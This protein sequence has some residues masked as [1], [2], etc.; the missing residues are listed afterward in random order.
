MNKGNITP[1]VYIEEKSA[2]PNS[3]IGVP[4]AIPAF[5]GYTEKAANKDK[6]LKN[7]PTRI[8]SLAEFQQY[9]GGAPCPIFEIIRDAQGR[10]ELKNP[11]SYFLLYYSMKFFFAN[12]GSDCYVVSIGDY[13]N[14]VHQADFNGEIPV[15]DANGHATAAI[16]PIGIRCLEQAPEP[17][18]LVIPDAVLLD[19]KDCAEIQKA[20]LAHCSRL[21]N[22]FAILDVP[23]PADQLK[24]PATESLIQDFRKQ[25]GASNLLWGAAYYPYLH[26]SVTDA[27]SISFRNI[28]PEN[29]ELLL[30]LLLEEQRNVKQSPEALQETEN[31]LKSILQKPGEN[32]NSMQNQHQSLL[33]LSPLYKDI[34][35]LL[36]EKINIL[37]PSGAMAGIYTTVDSNVGVFQSPANIS[38]GSALSTVA[39]L[40]NAEQENLNM[41]ID[42]KAVNAIRS[43]PGKGVLVWGARTLDGNSQDWRYINVR[44]TVIFLQQSIKYALLP[45]TF[46]ANNNSTWANV[47]AMITNFLATVW[48]N[49]GL[50]GAEP[51][52]AF[53]V[54]V[55]LGVTMTAVDVQEGLMRVSVKV[56]L[57][58]PA[59]FIVLDFEQNMQEMA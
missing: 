1:G 36:L 45:Y 37:P 56:A 58:R 26:T 35:R 4:T 32:F 47:E 50:A 44:R 14:G 41:P 18:L 24:M 21:G 9:F 31:K 30:N 25:I 12:G 27:N 57:V 39:P 52:D 7:V 48:R 13:A 2:F 28:A 42:G 59:E 22:R 11:K 20:M 23:I 10:I 33:L 53:Q 15:M 5:V 6:N 43:F 54:Q 3:V 49:G 51:N 19:K 55:G 40:S 29:S 38:I 46:S 16:Q 17:S 34:M 8:G